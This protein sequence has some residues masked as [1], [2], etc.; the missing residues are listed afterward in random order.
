M[1]RQ[2][3]GTMQRTPHLTSLILI[4]ALGLPPAAV[5]RAS[6]SATDPGVPTFHNEV[7]RLLQAECQV[8]HRP[9]GANLGGMVAPMALVTYDQTRP[10]ARSMARKAMSR[11]MPP[12]HASPDQAGLFQN[13]RTLTDD[14][15]DILVRWAR[16]G[17][18]AGDPKK[19]P[20]QRSWPAEDGWLIGEPDLVLSVDEPFFVA[21]DVEDQYIYL[22]TTMTKELL[23]ENRYVKAIEFRPGSSAVH[24]IIV[25]S[26]GGIA[27]GN[28]PQV[29]RDGVAGVL[30]A[31][32]DLQWQMHY[33]KEKGEGTGV[34]DQSQ[35]AIRF[36]PKG[37]DPQYK[38]Q[39]AELSR[40]DFVL[41]AG[42]DNVSTET[43][44]VFEEDAQIVSF[45]PHMH[46]RGKAAKYV[47]HYP[48]G[49]V[50]TLLDVPKYDFN[51]QT[52]YEYAD[53]KRVPAGTKVVFTSWWDNSE[54]NPYNPDPTSTV[55]W[56]E[57]TTD[58]MSF[59]FMAFINESNS[60]SDIFGA[61]GN[62]DLT[63]V[64]AF[65]DKNR[66][67]KMQ[68]EETPE[69]A[70]AYFAMMDTNKD[71]AVD[72]DEARAAN[73][74]MDAQRK[75]IRSNLEKAYEEDHTEGKKS[76]GTGAKTGDR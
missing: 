42:A 24:H 4:L 3:I 36:Y 66:D 72:M 6:E 54:N 46:L 69:Q 59:G 11:E 30:T 13:E 58:E 1:T 27:P 65:T 32:K 74:F 43:E 7:S 49:K 53:F 26:L 21:D 19:A 76:E 63:A 67:G 60:G 33:H 18:P 51:W 10:W 38:L 20:E 64:V 56:G 15:I 34:W 52:T 17:A 16:A 41:P 28:D 62:I 39:N 2:E 8:C 22:K 35:V 44:F 9:N 47:A 73:R 55:R 71:D 37:E 23:P 75:T 61:D 5:A 68:R 14:E 50:E 29:Y 48:D 45:I 25:P 12:W 70:M 57:P 40:Y 31:G